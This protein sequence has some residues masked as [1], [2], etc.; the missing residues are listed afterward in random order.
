MNRTGIIC[1]SLA[2]VLVTVTGWAWAGLEG[3]KHDLSHEEWS[4]G[5]LCGACHMPH[6]T[7]P[8]KAAPLWDPNADLTRTF[9]TSAA[10]KA[11]PAQSTL[12]CLW[13]HDGTIATETIAG[14][15]TDR[16]IHKQ[17]PALFST[18]HQASNHPVGAEYP[19][20]D[21]GYN[22]IATVEASGAVVLPDNKVECV[23]CHDPHNDAD[24]PYML[25]MSN[26]RSAL[27]LMCH[28]K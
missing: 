3:S 26:R 13:C 23:S 2:V 6:R 8:P 17:N 16:F 25:V 28:K 9:G 24:E 20:F 19:Q 11:L 14:I 27:C 21:E 22:P 1:V 12:M 4:D 15:K 18:G 10:D 5:D 7:E